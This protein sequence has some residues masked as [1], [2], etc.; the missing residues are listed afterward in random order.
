[1][2]TDLGIDQ[3]WQEATGQ[4]RRILANDLLDGVRI[5][6]DHLE[7]RVTGAPK[8]NVTLQE[9]GLTGGS[10]SCGV[11]ELGLDLSDPGWRLKPWPGLSTWRFG[12]RDS[13]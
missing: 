7:V 3:I 8:I 9:V 5:F 6:P 12:E 1:M 11:G 13:T 10:A 2:L 4:E